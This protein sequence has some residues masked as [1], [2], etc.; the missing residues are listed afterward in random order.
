MVL[1][2]DILWNNCDKCLPNFEVH[3]DYYKQMMKMEFVHM[4]L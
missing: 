3:V 2:E 1:N 4:S